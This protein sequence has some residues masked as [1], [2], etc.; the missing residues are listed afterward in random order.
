MDND[1]KAKDLFE[2]KTDKTD[3]RAET[4]KRIHDRFIEERVNGFT[5]PSGKTHA[6]VPLAEAEARWDKRKD[7]FAAVLDKRMNEADDL[8]SAG[9]GD[10]PPGA[11]S[12]QSR[13][14]PRRPLP[15]RM[16]PEGGEDFPPELQRTLGREGRE[17]GPQGFFN[18]REQ[19]QL[20]DILILTLATIMNSDLDMQ[21]ANALMAGKEI[22]PNL[23]QHILDEAKRMKIPESHTPILQKIHQKLSGGQG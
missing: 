16:G 1:M 19:S 12:G 7:E 9:H 6:P 8:F 4:L 21:I 18:P 11:T 20:K 14:M 13:P 22:E 5:D 17:R 10:T 23:L 15:R 2:G 3:K